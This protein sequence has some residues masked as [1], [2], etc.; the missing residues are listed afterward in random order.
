MRTPFV[1]I[2]N[3]RPSA[4][5]LDANEVT[6]AF[7]VPL[8]ALL[9]AAN[10]EVRYLTYRKQRFPSYFYVYG[11]REIWGLTGRMLKAFL[12]VVRLV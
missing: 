5:R 7:E 6:E 3:R 10:P 8:A 12:D 4:Y 1:G 2:V 9:D 11:G